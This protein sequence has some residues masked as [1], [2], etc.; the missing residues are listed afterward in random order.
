M[1]TSFIR[2]ILVFS[3]T[4]FFIFGMFFVLPLNARAA[5]W[6]QVN[7]NGFGAAA[8][9]GSIRMHVYNGYIYAGTGNNG[10][11]QIYRSSNGTTWDPVTIDGFGDATNI[12]IHAFATFGAY[13]YASTLKAAG[14]AE[15]WRSTTGASGTW[16]Q[17]D[18][19]GFADANNIGVRAMMVFG[20]YLYAGT[21]NTITGTELWRTANG[22]SW[23]QA[24]SNGF[25]LA[26]NT[27]IRSLKVYNNQLY[28]GMDNSATGARIYRSSNGTTWNAVATS[29]FDGVDNTTVLMLEG[30]KGYLYAG[31]INSSTGAEMWR[32][33]TGDSGSW[34]RIVNTGFGTATNTWISYQGAVINN[35]FFVGTRVGG[36]PAAALMVSTNGTSWVQEGNAG[37]GDPNNYAL[38]AI[39]FKDYIYVGF[40]NMVTGTEIWRTNTK[41]TTLSI[42]PSTLPDGTVGQAYSQTLTPVSGTSP[43]VFS[44][45]G[46]LPEGLSLSS[47]GTISGTPTK[48]GTS[49]FTVLVTDGGSP[50][51]TFEQE[52]SLTI[53]LNVLPATGINTFQN[54]NKT[55][56]TVLFKY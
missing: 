1:N 43:Y 9:W 46:S 37:F 42:I 50:E 11:A 26:A 36:G 35:I 10:G 51:Q 52:Y 22:T 29:G 53:G 25:G 19:D 55:L 24:N 38:Y 41:S 7:S 14:G 3:I 23:T 13:I 8:N 40:S 30:F 47:T 6:T 21:I 17:V 48:T 32:S 33:S 28:A 2:K 45:Q 27:D 12:E 56:G 49:V 15:V 20:N 5:G 18:T 16:L 44:F 31:T 4:L 54:I 34:S 39:T